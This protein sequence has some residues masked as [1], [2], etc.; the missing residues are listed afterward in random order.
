MLPRVGQQETGH[1]RETGGQVA[2]EQDNIFEQEIR[3]LLNR[4][5]FINRRSG[6]F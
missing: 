2:P 6:C 5:I 4:I 1:L 3:L